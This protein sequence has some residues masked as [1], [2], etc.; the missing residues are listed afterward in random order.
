MSDLRLGLC[1]LAAVT[2]RSVVL[3]PF[4]YDG[5]AADPVLV[6]VA[7]IGLLRGSTAGAGWG[8]AAGL[9]V[10]LVPPADHPVGSWALVLL[11]VGFL[12]GLAADAVARRPL[13]GLA[14]VAAASFVATSLYAGL[15]TLLTPA[16]SGGEATVRITVL[17]V[18]ADTLLAAVVL[19][20]LAILRTW[21]RPSADASQR[22]SARVGAAAR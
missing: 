14:V 17:G 3:P 16:A 7:G 8:F 10:D 5:V 6:L 11:L 12:A 20:A 19:M 18:L 2:V 22:A 9:L 21:W 15:L 1:L 13:A 4:G